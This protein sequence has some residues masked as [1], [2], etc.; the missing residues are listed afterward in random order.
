MQSLYNL[1]SGRCNGFTLFSALVRVHLRS[2]LSYVQENWLKLLSFSRKSVVVTTCT[3]A[4]RT[5]FDLLQAVELERLAVYH[6]PNSTP[7][8]VSR[9]WEDMSPG[10]WSEVSALCLHDR[11]YCV[12]QKL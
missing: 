1:Q 6:N 3:R 10:E 9:K 4:H 7:W 11:S 5:L 8:K 12:F 2:L